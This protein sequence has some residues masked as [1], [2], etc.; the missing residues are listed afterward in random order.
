MKKPLVG[1]RIKIVKGKNY[2]GMEGK[3]EYCGTCCRAY[4]I[5]FYGIGNNVKYKNYKDKLIFIK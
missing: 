5:Q 3:I 4:R 2:F 1:K